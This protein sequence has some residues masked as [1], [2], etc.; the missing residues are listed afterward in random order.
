MQ[1]LGYWKLIDIPVRLNTLCLKLVTTDGV[2]PSAMNT[3]EPE[4][5]TEMRRTDRD[6]K[7]QEKRDKRLKAK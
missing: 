7:M 2:K 3:W 5:M 4:C 1:S 6:I